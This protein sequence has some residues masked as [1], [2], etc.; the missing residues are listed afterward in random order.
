MRLIINKLFVIFVTILCFQSMIVAQNNVSTLKFDGVN[1]YV[2]YADDVLVNA[3]NYT[4][5]AWVNLPGGANTGGRIVQRFG[6][7]MLYYGTSNNKLSFGIY[8]ASNSQWY[9]YHS[10][11]NVLPDDF[12]WHHVAVIRKSSPASLKLYVDGID[13]TSTSYSG[14]TLRN[15]SGRNL[16]IGNDG[17]GD[18]YFK[19]K[20]DEIRLKNVAEDISG[21]NTDK[22]DSEYTVDANTEALFHFNEASGTTTA[23]EAGGS[24]TIHG[25]T[26][27]TIGDLWFP[28]ELADFNAKRA[29]GNIFLNWVTFS[30]INNKG[31]E[32]QR[33]IDGI[34]WKTLGFV[35]GHGTSR[36]RINYEFVDKNPENLNYYRLKQ[37]DYDG[38]STYSNIISI[39]FSKNNSI[40]LYPNP[41]NNI[42]NIAGLNT[43]S[44]YTIYNKSGMV[45]QKGIT[46]KNIDI[47]DFKTG[48]YYLKI[49]CKVHKFVKL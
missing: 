48:L 46:N 45:I 44:E 30:E 19:G 23:N 9:Y 18:H 21:L 42:V 33:S 47:K 24:A 20:I 39:V 28:I 17:G 6:C 29:N 40:T 7:Y 1:D 10:N 41:T 43:E 13:V 26:W 4:I 2:K 22:N 14:K 15:I 8:Q 5:E 35:E 34:T 16:Y 11:N 25:A 12:E 27:G 31:F 38:G 3:S 49:K 36:D 37:M 32:V